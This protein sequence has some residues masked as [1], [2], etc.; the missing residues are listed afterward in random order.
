[1][2]DPNVGVACFGPKL[3]NIQI[4]AGSGTPAAG[5]A[6]V[7]TNCAQQQIAIDNVTIYSRAFECFRAVTGY[8]G[9]A[10]LTINGLFCT[11]S[12]ASV[13]GLGVVLN[14]GAAVTTLTNTIVE[15]GAAFTGTG[16]SI[17]ATSGGVFRI[18]GF[19]CEQV[20]TCINW[21]AT[22][23]GA[24]LDVQHATGGAAPNCVNV[25][26]RQNTAVANQMRV[27]VITP[28]G[29][30]TTVNNGGTPTTGNIIADT[31]F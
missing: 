28:N 3:S 1:L 18:D 21:A 29:C 13:D 7:F 24:L 14:Y 16:V 10:S 19:H 12:S 9:A 6:L 26:T 22:G 15:S 4:F 11:V 27:G 5:I 23:S 8:G 17:P 25:I 30:T 2:G 20:N 31:V